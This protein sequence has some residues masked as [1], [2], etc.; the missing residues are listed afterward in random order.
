MIHGTADL[1]LQDGQ[2]LAFAAFLLLALHPSLHRD[3]R[4]QH[5]ARGFAEGPLQ[6][7]VADLFAAEAFHLAGAFVGA[8]H[9]PAVRQEIA[10]F[11]KSTYTIN[12]VKEDQA[13]DRPDA[14]NG[15]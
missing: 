5:Q 8:T 6:M 3:A 12:L 4:P 11:G 7:G 13:E 1:G 15:A 2:R 14:G 10:G 9:E